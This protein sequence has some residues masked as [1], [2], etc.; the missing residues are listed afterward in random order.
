MSHRLTRKDMKRDELREGLGTVVD[1]LRD[2]GRL[3]V[4]GIVALLVLVAIAAG[5]R[6][7]QQRREITAAEDLAEALRVYQ[8]PVV[9][10]GAT[11]TDPDQ[12]TFATEEARAASA[13]S[14]FDQV[15]SDHG[16]TD[17]ADI[18]M[19]YR[20]ELA[21]RGGDLA[22][23]RELWEEFLERQKDNMLAAEVALNLM[24][25]DRLEGRG[26]ELIIR[27]NSMLD[28]PD[29]N[30][31]PTDVLLNQLAITLEDSGREEEARR[32]YRRIID[33]FPTS[34]YVDEARVRA[35]S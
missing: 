3:I 2:Y 12:P 23:A 34:P 10:S 16:G 18:A 24:S 1:F 20:A 6:E 13:L 21:T 4:A 30:S 14:M 29:R 22:L 15:R 27:L 8:A 32:A 11:P 31:L 33:E 9:P 28:S 26:D 5:Y 7:Y 25:L 19:V 17:A 35:E